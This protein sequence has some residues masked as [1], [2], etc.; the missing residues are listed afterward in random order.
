MVVQHKKPGQAIIE[1]A[2]L[3]TLIA[4][5][6]AAAVDLGNAYRT[7]QTLI[8]ATAEAST[9]LA[10]HPLANCVTMAADVPGCTPIS[11]ADREARNRF[12]NEQ[13][14]MVGSVGSTLDLDGNGQDDLKE[15]GWGFIDGRVRIKVADSTQV[16][17]GIDKNFKGTSNADC[18]A[19]KRFDA[20]AKP[21]YIVV[22]SKIIYRP[23]I[24]STVL[25]REMA[26]TAESVTQIVEGE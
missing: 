5:L 22:Q 9:Y 18:N 6:L 11:G 20:A 10:H 14:P 25:G 21:C 3:I 1:F 15:Y 16:V 23:M 12:R 7:Y 17:N 24:L 19:R 8:N 26:I 13:G 2:L 4:L